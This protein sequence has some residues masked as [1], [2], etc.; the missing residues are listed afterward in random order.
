MSPDEPRKFREDV[1]PMELVEIFRRRWKISRDHPLEDGKPQALPAPIKEFDEAEKKLHDAEK[2]APLARAMDA[3][4]G[5]VRAILP[6]G[7]IK[8]DVTSIEDI[9][10]DVQIKRRA[11]A[12]EFPPSVRHGLIGLAFS[13]GGIRSATFN[14]GI[15]QSLADLGILRFF[16]YLSTVSGGGY[17]GSWFSA[18]IWHER[19]SSRGG[20][21]AVETQLKPALSARKRGKE[22]APPVSTV[23]KYPP[24]CGPDPIFHLRRYSNYLTPRLGVFSQDTWSA[25]AIYVRNL[26]LIQLILIPALAAVLLLPR[27]LVKAFFEV[28]PEFCLWIPALALLVAVLI[29]LVSISSALN[30]L[31]KP[32]GEHF[33]LLDFQYRILAPAIVASLIFSW[34]FGAQKNHLQTLLDPLR[35]LRQWLPSAPVNMLLRTLPLDTCAFL[36]WGLALG[37]LNVAV[38]LICAV[39]HEGEFRGV[40]IYS[41]FLSGLIGGVLL[42][43]L[44]HFGLWR[45]RLVDMVSFGPPLFL[46][47]FLLAITVQVGLRAGT[48]SDAA[49][50]W[51]ASMGAWLLIYVLFWGGLFAISFY[52]PLGWEHLGEWA[53]TK[54][55]LITAW[56]G[57]TLAA[58]FAGK[59]PST[60]TPGNPSKLEWV[61]KI[62][63]VIAVLGL[64]IAVATVSH[65]IVTQWS[66]PPKD[67]AQSQE[68]A[69]AASQPKAIQAEFAGTVQLNAEP[70]KIDV[71]L[72]LGET[73]RRRD[74]TEEYWATIRNAKTGMIFAL[75]VLCF[76]IVVIFANRVDVNEFSLHAFYRNRLV[77]CYL[78]ASRGG[79][80]DFDPITGFDPKD[81][82]ALSNLRPGPDYREILRPEGTCVYDGPYLIINTALN[83][84]AGKELAWQQRKAASFVLTP[85]FCGSGE[86]GYQ[87]TGDFCGSV[88]LGTAF[89][90]SGAAASPNMGYHSSGPMA[91]LLTLFNVRL[92]WWVRNP[93]W[94]GIRGDQRPVRFHYLLSELFGQTTADSSYVYLSDGGHFENLGLY[95]L[96]RRRCKYIVC[97]DAGADSLAEFEDIGNAIRKIRSD[98]GVNIEIDL[99][100]IRPQAGQRHSRWHQAI[101][102]IRYDQVKDGESVGMLVYIKASLTGDESGDVLEHAGRHPAFP[103]DTTVDQ[104]FD[105]SQFESYRKLGEHVGWEVFRCAQAEVEKGADAVFNELRHHWVSVPTSLRDSFLGQ[106]EALVDLEARLRDDPEL[107]GYD[108]EIYPEIA[109]LLGADPT[110]WPASDERAALHFSNMQLQL[111]ENVFVALEFQKYHAYALNRGWM[112]LFRRWATT[113]TFQKLWPG[114]RG[115][116]SRQFSDFVEEHLVPC[117]PVKIVPEIE[118]QLA[119]RLADEFKRDQL[120][121]EIAPQF[122]KLLETGGIKAWSAVPKGNSPYREAWGVAVAVEGPKGYDYQLYVWVRGAYRNLGIGGK[123]LHDALAELKKDGVKRKIL[124]DLGEEKRGDPGYG[125]RKAA[126]FRLYGQR[127][128]TREKEQPVQQTAEKEPKRLRLSCE[129]NSEASS[130]QPAA[131]NSI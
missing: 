89:A 60:G 40:R 85:R 117:E 20:F 104:F 39:C 93:K 71:N 8:Q 99:D 19:N 3:I 2:P 107:K 121:A 41:D 17:I 65:T 118:P 96:V 55:T 76:V 61:I 63:P 48:E 75:I 62:G 109:L 91:F 101:G 29:M 102:T 31:K 54:T 81:D 128:F 127:G 67:A 88:E 21:A 131:Q 124:V 84:M 68:P 59:S 15:L 95:E 111:M 38:Y 105:E 1:F 97:C 57:S 42:Y 36:Y 73:P 83:Q 90:I 18:W 115:G 58:V 112:N 129:L 22:E 69:T 100:M 74:I 123:L 52:G 27:I 10:A 87:E 49:R 14:L 79:D 70:T 9:R 92:G 37:L 44:L 122:P 23:G 53:K 28:S 113:A 4:L 110:S 125:P 33:Q 24:E 106:Q 78:G 72:K 77:R 12:A 50:E 56:L 26:L 86:T 11:L 51:R 46:I 30:R 114:L 25:I 13:G 47:A 94:N 35:W 126:W 7:K 32:K 116:Y 119:R 82:F 6:K 103:H 80:R 98:L 45:W 66:P 34:L 120:S 108:L 5:W 130:P 16:D 43:A 64:L